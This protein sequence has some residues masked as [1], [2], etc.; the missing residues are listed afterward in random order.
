MGPGSLVTTVIN[1]KLSYPENLSPRTKTSGWG[2]PS[3]SDDILFPRHTLAV[4]LES[5]PSV[6]GRGRL[7]IK[8]VTS[9]GG[10]GCC[11]SDEIIEVL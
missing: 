7:W 3:G 10:I 5:S 4:I 8:V 2:T 9:N 1:I 11:F 6:L